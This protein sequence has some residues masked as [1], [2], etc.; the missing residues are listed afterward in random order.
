MIPQLG[1]YALIFALCLAIAQSTLPLIGA[2]TKRVA[3]MQLAHTTAYGQLV[4]IGIAFSAL[5]FAFL[6]DDF[7]VAYVAQNSNSHLP[8][9]YKFC[10]VWGAHEGSL[11]LWVFILSMWMSL[12]AICNRSLPLAM[13]SRVLAVLSMISFG[14]LLFILTTSNPFLLSF[15]NIPTDGQDLNPLLQDPGLVIHPPMLYMGYVGFSVVFAFAIA[16]LINGKL[17]AVWAKWCRPWTLVAWSFLTLGIVLGS[18]WAYRVLGWGGWWFWDPVENASLMPWLVGT[19]LIHS[20][21]VVEKRDAFKAWTVLL[22]ISTFSL[23]L[24]GTFLVRSGVLISVHA[25][26][27]DP[28]RGVFM[29]MFLL[30]VIGSS[31]LLYAWRAHELNSSAQFELCSRETFILSNNILLT[32]A[33]VTILLGTLY[34]LIIDGLN[35]GKISVGPPYFNTIFFPIV[36]LLLIFMGTVPFIKWYDTKFKI[37]Y[38]KILL[39]FFIAVGV[40]VLLVE[41]FVGKFNFS[42]SIGLGLALWVIIA[43]AQSLFARKLS[44]AKVAMVLA[45]IGFAVCVI[46]VVLTSNYSVQREVRMQPKDTALAGPYQFQFLGVRGLQGPNYI[47]AEGG[48]R[49]TKKGAEVTLLQPQLRFYSV[50]EITQAKTAIDV[51]LFRDL[52]VALGE[53]LD[54][55]A[56]SLRIYYKPFVRWIWAGGL[57]MML[58]GIVAVGDRRYRLQKERLK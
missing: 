14:F 55:D 5:V 43:T 47:G 23:S 31:L 41:F 34:P 21:F 2:A 30:I 37:I 57:L 11:L 4:F 29:L 45:H 7:S 33:M 48:V 12:V 44:A 8:L 6:T 16:A 32:V 28:A 3:W 13:T 42:V 19:A 38:K 56:W 15:P 51:G 27:V 40:G 18:G 9:I 22:A 24:I 1:Y 50:R 17:D 10:A 25:F 46:G 54:Q 39:I 26:A 52:Y 20:L 36:V 35:L 53:P 49:V 58:G